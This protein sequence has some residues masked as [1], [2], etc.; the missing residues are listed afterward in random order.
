MSP[1][2]R[3]R[4]LALAGALLVASASPSAFA[5]AQPGERQV[6]TWAAS[7]AACHN[8]DGL[9]VGGMPALAGRPADDLYRALIEFR[10]GKRPATVM[11]QHARGYTEDELRRIADW[12]A[13]VKTAR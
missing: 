4:R 3:A 12:F 2:P 7:C 13:A 8:T 11:H 9:S 10:T 1:T 5:Q 6:R